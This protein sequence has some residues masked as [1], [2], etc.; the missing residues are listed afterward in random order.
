MLWRELCNVIVSGEVVRKGFSKKGHLN[1]DKWWK[2]PTVCVTGRG[3][4]DSEC[5]GPVAGWSLAC[6]KNKIKALVCK[7]VF[8]KRWVAEIRL[9]IFFFPFFFFNG[10][11]LGIWRFLDLRLNPVYTSAIAVQDPLTHWAGPGIQSMPPQWPQ[12]L[13]LDS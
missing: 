5:K 12:P 10:C 6:W 11:T 1:W 8:L 3:G 7:E 4:G 2:E 13:Q 9:W